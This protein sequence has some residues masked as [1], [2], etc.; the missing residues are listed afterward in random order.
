[1]SHKCQWVAQQ[2][3]ARRVVREVVRDLLEGL[4]HRLIVILPDLVRGLIDQ[5]CGRARGLVT[6][7]QVPIIFEDRGGVKA[8]GSKGKTHIQITAWGSLDLEV[9][10]R[11][12]RRWSLVSWEKA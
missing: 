4:V 12:L 8:V 5:V 9:P 11:N 2:H 1:M 7:T 6:A 3:E 10:R